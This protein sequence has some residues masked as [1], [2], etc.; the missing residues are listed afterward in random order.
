MLDYVESMAW[1]MLA[2]IGHG[3]PSLLVLAC[4]ASLACSIATTGW[5]AASSAPDRNGAI[6]R[7][8]NDPCFHE[9][10]KDVRAINLTSGQTILD[11][12]GDAILIPGSTTKFTPSAAALLGLM[13]H[14]R[15][16]AAFLSLGPLRNGVLQGDLYRKG[17]GDPDA[18][19][20]RGV[21]ARAWPA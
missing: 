13:P 14:Y 1:R 19:P 4:A 6:S 21:V 9:G 8:V 5:P 16:H 7:L 3:R 10:Q 11:I 2:A 17:Y 12:D 15:L 18:Y 20:G